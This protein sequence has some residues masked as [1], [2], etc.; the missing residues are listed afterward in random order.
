TVGAADFFTDCWCNG[1][2]LGHREGG[3][4]PHEFDLTEALTADANGQRR[5]WIVLRVEDPMDNHEQPVGKQWCWYTTTSGIWQTV[6]IEPR[7]ASYIECFRIRPDL[8]A[9]M[10]E[11]SIDCSNAE[12]CAVLLMISPPEG[13]VYQAEL[14]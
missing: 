7:S 2:H 9:G 1:Q 5:G 4:T 6:F 10:V 14:R 12:G 3:Y 13:E 11:W 8:K